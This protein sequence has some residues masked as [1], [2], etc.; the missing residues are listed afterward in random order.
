MYDD[1]RQGGEMSSYVDFTGVRLLDAV[2][3][4]LLRP[5]HFIIRLKATE[6][7]HGIQNTVD[8]TGRPMEPTIALTI[9]FSE[10][11]LLVQRWRNVG[12]C[13]LRWGGKVCGTIGQW[14]T[15]TTAVR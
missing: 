6:S 7:G 10:L 5:E 12:S 9:R 8:Q 2:E 3:K 11:A 13:A 14:D 15:R 4:Y 1:D